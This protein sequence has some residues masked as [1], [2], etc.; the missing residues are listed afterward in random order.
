MKNAILPSTRRSRKMRLPAT[1]SAVEDTSAE[2][3]ATLQRIGLRDVVAF[4][5]FYPSS[6]DFS[7]PRSTAS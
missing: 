4:Q 3:S 6:K 1:D 7:M 5:D 2:D